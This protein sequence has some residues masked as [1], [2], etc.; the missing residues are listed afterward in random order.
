MICELCSITSLREGFIKCQITQST[1]MSAL[2]KSGK[3][4]LFLSG[5]LAG[6]SQAAVLMKRRKAAR[7][8][9]TPIRTILAGSGT[10]AV[11]DPDIGSKGINGADAD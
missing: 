5:S 7:T 9:P 6:V 3:R 4:T 1:V 11:S 2:K 10:G 8:P